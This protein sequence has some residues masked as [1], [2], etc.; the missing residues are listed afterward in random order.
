MTYLI[1]CELC[2]SA[3]FLFIPQEQNTVLRATAAA[4]GGRAD[5]EAGVGSSAGGG[6][7]AGPSGLAAVATGNHTFREL[8]L[9]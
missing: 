5:G 9:F 6:D 3:F 1:V 8:G 2:E 7:G 4:A